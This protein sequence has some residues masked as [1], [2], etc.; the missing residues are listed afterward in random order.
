VLLAGV[1]PERLQGYFQTAK[2]EALTDRTVTDPGKLRSLIDDARRSGYSA[3][4]D[5]LAYGVIAVAVPVFDQ[6]RRV[7]ASLNT[8]SHSRKITRTKLVRDRLAMLEKISRQISSD[9]ASVPWL[10]LSAQV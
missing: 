6:Q 10:S 5:E 4:E 2:F 7:V 3:V 1:G 9:L 8:S